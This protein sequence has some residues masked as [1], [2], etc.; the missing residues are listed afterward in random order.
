MALKWYQLADE[1]MPNSP[2][3]ANK[4]GNA[5][6]STGDVLRGESVFTALVKEHPEYAQGWSNLGYVKMINGGNMA[7]AKAD[8]DHALA[9]DPDYELAMMNKAAWLLS[10]EKKQE[11]VAL[12]KKVLKKNPMNAQAKQALAQ[13]GA[14]N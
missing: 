7:E 3:F 1:K 14:H 10:N 13:I 6:V 11:A 9:L 4:L 8:I 5:F 2:E 12:L